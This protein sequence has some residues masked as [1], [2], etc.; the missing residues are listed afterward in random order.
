VR[1][2][3]FSLILF[4]FSL[5]LNAQWLFKA[6]I[7]Y[8]TVTSQFESYLYPTNSI[9]ETKITPLILPQFS[10]TKQYNLNQTFKFYYGFAFNLRGHDF[11]E[12]QELDLSPIGVN[13]IGYGETKV[14][15]IFMSL[16]LPVGIK[17]EFDIQTKPSL[18]I[19][20]NPEFI[21]ICIVNG[22]IKKRIDSE[23][24]KTDLFGSLNT[25]EWIYSIMFSAGNEFDILGLIILPELSY[26]LGL[27]SI[28]EQK[29]SRIRDFQFSLGFQL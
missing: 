9:V 26:Y 21:V 11:F 13:A 12:C 3:I 5:P 15:Y 4:L 14:R 6:G 1:L 24:R 22:Y 23:E 7:N 29:N 25:K 10:F 20:F 16:S 28:M 8:S 19:S 18:G 27:N 17:Y 2:L